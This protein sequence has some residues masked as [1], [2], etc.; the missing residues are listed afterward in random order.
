MKKTALLTSFFVFGWMIINAQKKGAFELSA[1]PEIGESV[2]SNF[3]NS[4]FAWGFGGGLRVQAEYFL[5]KNFSAFVTAG[6]I[7]YQGRTVNGSY[8]LNNLKTVPIG[9]GV[10]YYQGKHFHAGMQVGIGIVQLNDALLGP[11]I[12]GNTLYYAPQIGYRCRIFKKKSIDIVIRYDD[13][14]YTNADFG[15]MGLKVAYI[16]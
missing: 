13:Y 10:Q 11:L 7:V 8:P 1:G 2:G 9:G 5:L 4:V 14:S 15:A 6:Y 16:F 12:N 3:K